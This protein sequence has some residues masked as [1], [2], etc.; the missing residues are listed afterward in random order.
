MENRPFLMEIVRSIKM[1][2]V[3]SLLN[4]QERPMELISVVKRV[5]S[6]SSVDGSGSVSHIPKPSSINC[7][8]KERWRGFPG[9]MCLASNRDT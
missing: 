9:E 8:R 5:H 2:V 6:C 4:S 3:E 1:A 7:P